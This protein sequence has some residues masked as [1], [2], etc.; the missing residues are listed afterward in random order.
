MSAV[1]N[2]EEVRKADHAIE[3]IFLRRWSPRA[4]SGE[5]LSEEELLTLFEAARWAPSTYNEQEWRFLYARRDTPQWPLFFDLL[6][7]ANQVWCRRAAVL[8]V[9]LARKVFTRNGKPN[10]VHVF[11]CG[12]A[13]ENLALQATAMGLVAHGMAGF[14]FDKARTALRVPEHFDV[15]AMFALGRPGDP[16]ELPPELREREIPSDRRPVE[17]SICEGPYD[18]R[19]NW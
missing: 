4:M 17:E 11:D 16:A 13:W 12:S 14:D 3:P 2:L 6:M 19:N 8:V 7:E 5:P 15:A 1:S 10:P 9:V 18:P